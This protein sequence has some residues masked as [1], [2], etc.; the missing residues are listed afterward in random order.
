MNI[1][2]SYDRPLRI[3]SKPG[4]RVGFR[5]YL[6]D[7]QSEEQ[8]NNVKAATI[9]LDATGVN[10]VE[11]TYYEKNEHDTIITGL[12]HEPIMGKI[13]VKSDK[14]EVDLSVWEI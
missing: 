5:V 11:L 10:E 6:F 12:D 8:I 1:D 4:D 3:I 2:P 7:A 14:H 9:H 13:T